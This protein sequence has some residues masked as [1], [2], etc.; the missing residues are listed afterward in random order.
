MA[1]LDTSNSQ[2]KSDLLPPRR[3]GGRGPSLDGL[4]ASTRHSLGASSR[5]SLGA[6]SHHSMMSTTSTHTNSGS[7]NPIT[8][9]VKLNILVHD[10]LQNITK[11]KQFL[12]W[13][14]KFLD[15]FDTYMTQSGMEP[16]DAASGEL[17]IHLDTCLRRSAVVLERIA[18]GDL[19]PTT[20]KKT[21][22]ASLA[23]K[24]F[25]M[26]IDE[27]RVELEELIPATQIDEK[28]RRYTKFHVG[29]SLIKAGFPQFV[30]MKEL[31]ENVRAISDQTYDMET[32]YDSLDKQQRELFH[33][34]KTQVS[35]FCDVMADLDL[36]DIM[37][38]CIEFLHAPENEE[39]DDVEELTIFVRRY[40]RYDNSGIKASSSN[41]SNSIDSGT[42]SDSD[43]S[44]VLSRPIMVKVYVE[45]R[46]TMAMVA[47]MVAED[48]GFQL[49]PL[50][51]ID[52]T[53]QLTVRYANDVVVEA[54]KT[55]TLKQLG[56]EDGDVLT[57]EL[58]LIP[59]R[60]RRILPSGERMELDILI[61]PLAP[62]RQLKFAVEHQQHQRGDGIRSIPAEDQR[63]SL[64]SV[65]LDDNDKSCSGYGIVSGSVLDLEPKTV[66]IEE[67]LQSLE[68][69]IVIVDTKYGVMFSVDRE[70][71]IEKGVL[72]PKIINANDVFLE[73]TQNDFDKNLM[74]KSMMSSPN[75]NVKPRIVI[76]KMEVEDYELDGADEVK[77]MWG[78]QLK[79]A[80]KRQ[81][82]TEIFFVDIMTQAVG[83]L[84]RKK[85]MDM[86]FITVVKATDP[87]VSGDNMELKNTLEQAEKD[88]QKYDFFVFEIRKIFG[89]AFEES[90][91]LQACLSE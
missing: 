54:P 26:S 11:Y 74:Q 51:A 19:S 3:K 68:E 25:G 20:Q 69:C 63:L 86:E 9:D 52:I 89:I 22:K 36:Y 38:K 64:G 79:K 8:N 6:S 85:L 4:G 59:I 70:E 91:G 60:V 67:A 81:R 47:T 83:L 53:E 10:K 39:G 35:R 34:Y 55:T 66:H 58:A 62:L 13:R 88:Q 16:A 87:S 31:E 17:Q 72:T 75:L 61:D 45:D 43:G 41:G 71:A 90:L 48:L 57:I 14:C 21:V 82:G 32:D 50:A 65:E 73:A 2:R 40:Q 76:P 78:I 29:A 77:N 7:K 37:L 49:K 18:N 23:L 5:H 15:R 56:I 28:R 80:P 1:A 42:D 44:S 33:Q 46:E 84:D 30:A 12:R 24:E 27:C